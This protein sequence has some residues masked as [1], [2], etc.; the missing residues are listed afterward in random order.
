[1]YKLVAIDIDGTLLRND[2]TLSDKNRNAINKA[3]K[4]GIK[5]V[6]T[7]GRPVLGI[8]NYLKDLDLIGE[9]EY[10]IADNGA[11]VY[12]TKNFSLIHEKALTGKDI[13]YI[14]S[15]MKK[16]NNE[17]ELHVP[18]GGLVEKDSGT[19]CTKKRKPYMDIK[20]VDIMKHVKDEDKIFKILVFAE[21]KTIEESYK[22]IPSELLEKYSAI[23]ALNNMFEFMYKGSTKASGIEV[24]RKYLGIEKEQIIAIGD[25]MNDL[26]MIEYAGL[27]VAMGNARAEVKSKAD[28]ITKSNEEDGVAYVLEKF[29][30]G[31]EN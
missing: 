23:R 10:A 17:I 19:I 16:D 3:V 8:M 24:L 30:F 4:M 14:Y 11:T 28:F 22:N 1:M 15:Y 5:V 26:D 29:C 9:N 13:K 21:E 27:G 31:S 12:D 18:E 2:K 25:E 6:I 7:T 20:T